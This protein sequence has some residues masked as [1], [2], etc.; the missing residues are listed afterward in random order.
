MGVINISTNAQHLRKNQTE[1]EKK[2][3][4]YISKH[5]INGLKFRRQHPIDIYIVDFVCIERKLVIEIDGSWHFDK[6]EYDLKRSYLLE[7]KGYKVLR[8]WNNEVLENIEVVLEKIYMEI[9]A[10]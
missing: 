7:W 1:A 9:V 8:F 6:Q 10:Y 3:W 2:L 4:S 5:Q